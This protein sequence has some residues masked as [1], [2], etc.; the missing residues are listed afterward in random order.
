MRWSG[1]LE[2]GS[3]A[4]ICHGGE[5]GESQ[6]RVSN[7]RSSSR[8]RSSCLKWRTPSM[9]VFH[10]H[11]KI[12]QGG[13]TPQKVL[14][15]FWAQTTQELAR[16]FCFPKVQ[17]KRKEANYVEHHFDYCDNHRNNHH[18]HYSRCCCAGSKTEIEENQIPHRSTAWRGKR[19]HGRRVVVL[20]D[21][22]SRY[23]CSPY[24]SHFFV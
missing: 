9:G 6:Q 24:P 15:G 22:E 12:K 3:R 13:T 23:F 17:Y 5:T 18:C 4:R 16:A 11:K 7:Y 14:A 8:T 21:T 19:R 20:Q 1:G 10:S 2:P